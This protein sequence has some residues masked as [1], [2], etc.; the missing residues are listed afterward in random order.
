[1]VELQGETVGIVQSVQ[2]EHIGQGVLEHL[3]EAVPAAQQTITVQQAMD[4]LLHIQS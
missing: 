1:V 2:L 4:P 3:L